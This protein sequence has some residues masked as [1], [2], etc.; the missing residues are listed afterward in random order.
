MR[1][2][3]MFQFHGTPRLMSRRPPGFSKK[4]KKAGQN[5]RS[6]VVSFL[7]RRSKR[8]IFCCFVFVSGFCWSIVA[9]DGVFYTVFCAF[10]GCFSWVDCGVDSVFW[11]FFSCGFDM[12]FV[13]LVVALIVVLIMFFFVF[14]RL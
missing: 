12:V 10:F 13:G 8:S 11:C 14:L 1:W 2:H 9:V 4:K 6:F 7:K 5:G 3:E